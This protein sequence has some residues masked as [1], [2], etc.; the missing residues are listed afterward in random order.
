MK[1]LLLLCVSTLTTFTFFAQS[2]TP[3]IDKRVEILSIVSRL[4]EYDEYNQDAA[5]KYVSAI[6]LHFDKFKSDTLIGFA[7]IVREELGIGFDAVMSLAVNLKQDKQQ[8]TLQPNWKNDIDTRWTKKA[9]LQFVHLLNQ[10]YTKAKAEL[11]FKNQENYYNKAL[12]AFNQVQVKFNQQWYYNYYGITPKDKFSIIVGCGNGGANYGP[13][14]NLTKTVRQ[15]YAVMG[16]WSFDKD[17]NPVFKVEDYLP[18]L[19]HEFNHSFINPLL[20]KHQSDT[21]LS[22]SMLKILDTMKTEMERQAYG[23]WETILNESLVRASVVRY[24]FKNNDGDNN[25]VNDEI[26]EQLNRGFLWT[27]EL[28]SLLE[29]YENNRTKYPSIIDFYPEI[30]TFFKSTADSISSVKTNFEIKLPK[31]ISIEPFANNTEDVDASINEMTIHFNETMLGKDYSI[32]YGEAG[33]EAYPIKSVVGYSN[34]NKSI[35]LALALK[36]NT[37]YE[38][39]LSGRA[40]K[41]IEGYAL[42]NYTIK[43]KTKK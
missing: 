8:F 29:V 26:A 25:I 16:S 5:K 34:N 14:I 10:F 3:T 30:I 40:F 4:A 20:F 11:F 13:S 22:N 2:L 33:K 36:P 12:I 31:V 27:K 42:K 15:V 9:T 23:N 24:L 6:H 19:I 41:N 38:L 32:N 7:K 35:I 28:V 17:G 18:T 43:F 21:V 39:V 37:A 1:K